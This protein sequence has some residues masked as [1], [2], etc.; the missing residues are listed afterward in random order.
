[1]SD[2][3]LTL[4]PTLSDPRLFSHSLDGFMRFVTTVPLPVLL[5]AADRIDAFCQRHRKVS[6]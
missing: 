1:M 3:I 5:D 4:L 6:A 2:A